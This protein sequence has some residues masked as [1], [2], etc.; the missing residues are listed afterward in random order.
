MNP[1]VMARGLG[2]FSIGLGLTEV[3]MPD[4]LARWLGMEGKE[5]L[6]QLYGAREIA[7][8]LGCLGQTP[9]T[10]WVYGRVA[11]DALDVATLAPHLSEENPQRGN[12]GIALAAVLGVTVMDVLCAGWLTEGRNGPINRMVRPLVER[13]EH[14]NEQRMREV[15]RSGRDYASSL[16]AAR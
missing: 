5:G 13:K 4:K 3:L 9:P 10:G 2:W 6:I 11:G 12:V 16:A 7:T 8:G 1:D 14:R 15:E